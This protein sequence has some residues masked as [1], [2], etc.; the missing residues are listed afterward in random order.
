MGKWILMVDENKYEF[1]KF[2]DAISMF[3]AE[4]I[5]HIEVND[6]AYTDGGEPFS[7]GSFFF[8]K[9]DKGTI[10]DEE[11]VAETRMKMLFRSLIIR[12][13]DYSIENA[14]KSI[15]GNINYSGKNEFDDELKINIKSKLR[16]ISLDI[17]YNDGTDDEN[18]LSSNAF[19]FDDPSIEYY[20][21]SNWIIN[22]SR[23]HNIGKV[24]DIKIRLKQEEKEVVFHS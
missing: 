15:K 13:L 6:E 2:N 11:I 7:T 16:E 14:I 21:L 12:D 23:R 22:T 3:K 24:V 20:F 4:I 17:I 10:K 9:Y 18:Y 1:D 19:I 5:K 8:Y